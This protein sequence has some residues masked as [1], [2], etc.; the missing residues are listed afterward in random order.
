MW[1]RAVRLLALHDRSEHEIRARLA[2]A[3][4]G[5]ATINAT[6]RRLKQLH[7]LDDRR[8]AQSVT[9]QAL[10]RG[11]GSDYVRAQLAVK[12]VADTLIEAAVAASFGDETALA[13]RALAHR[14][15]TEPQRPAERARAARFL[16]RRGFPEAVVF[17]IL[18]EAC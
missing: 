18:E 8:F 3:G 12:G 6:V 2:A 17:A 1:D 10:R 16:L 9:E 13:R 15:P 5:A 4:A 7:Y 14:Y 11:Y